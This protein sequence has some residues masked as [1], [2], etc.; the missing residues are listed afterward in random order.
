LQVT[1]TGNT[2][3]SSTASCAAWSCGA[4]DFTGASQKCCVVTQRCLAGLQ[5]AE[6]AATK[7]AGAAAAAPTAALL[8]IATALSFRLL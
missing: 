2:V 6:A 3:V 4:G 7:V 5:A 1:C 8:L